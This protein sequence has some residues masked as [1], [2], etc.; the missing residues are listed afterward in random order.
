MKHTIVKLGLAITLMHAAAAPAQ[1][2]ALRNLGKT[3]QEKK[4]IAHFKI[5]GA[6][7]ETPSNLPPLFGSEPPQSLKTL[8][9]RFRQARHDDNVVAVVVDL[10][11]AQLGPAQLEE[12]HQA[13]RSFVAVDKE[14]FVH[15]D[16]LRTLTYALATGASHISVVPTGDIWL[17][18][19]YGETPYI[20]GTLNKIGCV[21]DFER[22]GN[23]KTATEPLM[24]EG[25]SE[26]SKEMMKWLFDGLYEDLVS[27][28]ASG[29]G[30]P[31]EKVRA[32]IDSGPYLAEEA[33]E[34]GLIDSVQHRQDFIADLKSRYGDSV[35]IVADYGKR[36]LFEIPDDNIFALFEFIKKMFNPSPKV[37]TKPSV[38]LVFAEGA[39]QT[40]S[41][42]MS[43]F[44]P[45]S[46][47]FST[48]IRKA[49]DKA[50]EDD[51]VKAVVLRVDSPGGSALAS[52]II[53][54]AAKRLA[55]AKPLIVSMGNVA[56][57]GGYYISCGAETIFADPSTITASIGVLGGKVV[58]TGMWDKLGVNWYPVQ[59]GAMAGMLSSAAPFSDT[60]RAKLRDYLETVYGIFKQHVTEARGE[61]L[62]KPVDEIA[63]GRVYTGAQALEL[64]L[65]DKLGGLDE[66]IKYAAAQAG[67][68]E[69]D[70]RVIP[71]PLNIFDWLMGGSEKEDEYADARSQSGLRLLDAPLLR[72]ILPILGRTDPLRAKATIQALERIELLANDGVLM[73]MPSEIVIR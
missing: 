47:A 9:E 51:S 38:A 14:V 20:R 36:D 35:E 50:R 19:L 11:D 5:K 13:M 7:T 63:G 46:G 56:G 23:Y 6:L 55:E 66:A 73:M 68:G 16:S 62:T 26:A 3:A 4:Q 59:R 17:V 12:L 53:L 1:F 30:L 21:P 25:P 31:P 72:S 33:L 48:T 60:E 43:P 40:G 61:R 27:V 15:A 70:I 65:V 52:E 18:G 41:G 64:G 54:N 37:Y 8:L 69:Y 28:I 22:C 24:R 44:G 32:L 10:Q 45:E 57:S 49:L 39:I 67:I 2:E 34:A 29:R 58:T 71:E 42:E